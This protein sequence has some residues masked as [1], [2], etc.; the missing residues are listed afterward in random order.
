M[1]VEEA[2]EAELTKRKPRGIYISLKK[3]TK[4]LAFQGDLVLHCLVGFRAISDSCYA[5]SL[6]FSHVDEYEILAHLTNSFGPTGVSI[7]LSIETYV[8]TSVLP[9]ICNLN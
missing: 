9:R 6:V 1:E 4:H 7:P 5:S 2:E 3:G 8:S